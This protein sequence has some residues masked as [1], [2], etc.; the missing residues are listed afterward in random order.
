M[1]ITEIATVSALVLTNAA[2]SVGIY[3][4]F[5]SR[6]NR[7]YERIDE[8]KNMQDKMFVRR[9]MCDVLH[10][11]TADNLVG[12][13]NRIVERLTVLEKKVE[14]LFGRILEKLDER[15]HTR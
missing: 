5:D 3:K 4:Y 11:N 8:I 12:A 15:S 10:K 7:V 2:A 13:E 6:I 14:D 9:E 1:L